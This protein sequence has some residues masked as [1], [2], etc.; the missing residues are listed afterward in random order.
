MRTFI[1]PD[2]AIIDDILGDIMRRIMWIEPEQVSIGCI[3]GNVKHTGRVQTRSDA[4]PLASLTR[5]LDGVGSVNDDLTWEVDNTKLH[6]AS[7]FPSP[8]I[9]RGR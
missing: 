5:Q 7:P 8:F 4:E 1:R 3:D 6:T 2:K 9:S